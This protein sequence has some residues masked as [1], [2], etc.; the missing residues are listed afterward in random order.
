M[1]FFS[2][3]NQDCFNLPNEG[4]QFNC[5]QQ[6]GRDL[7]LRTFLFSAACIV[8]LILLLK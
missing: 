8:G 4:D 7:D 3:N 6:A 5:F 2:E 1:S